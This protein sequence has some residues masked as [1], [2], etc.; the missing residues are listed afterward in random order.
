MRI[1]LLVS[2]LSLLAL[3]L[4]ASAAAARVAGEGSPD[5]SF[6]GDGRVLTDLAEG[7]KDRASSALSYGER[8]IVAGYSIK[9]PFGVRLAVAAYRPDGTLDPTFGTAGVVLSNVED[10]M[11]AE[12]MAIDSFGQIV[13]AGPS[14]AGEPFGSPSVARLLSDGRLDPSFGGGDGMV[15][16]PAELRVSAVRSD[17]GGGILVAGTRGGDAGYNASTE[18]AVF[19]LTRDGSPDPAFGT[20][21]LVTLDLSPGG[22]EEANDMMLDAFGRIVLL[23]GAWFPKSGGRTG[24][25]GQFAVARLLP[26]GK[27]DTAFAGRGYRLLPL[28]EWGSYAT[29]GA[30]DAAGRAILAGKSGN[31]LAFIAM[32]ESGQVD[33]SYG[34]GG[35]ALH[36][37][38]EEFLPGDVAGDSHERLVVALE[39]RGSPSTPRRGVIRCWRLRADGFFDPRFSRDGRV[40][41]RL[42]RRL[43]TARAVAFGPG[44]KILLA[45]WAKLPGDDDTDFAVISLRAAR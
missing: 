40:A 38:R 8:T 7:S 11:A 19:R 12:A 43:G 22:P 15:N 42:G 9:N 33:R 6:S 31:R 4:P 16:V 44:G 21:G 14:N 2:L 45:G 36:S 30:L 10:G 34:S 18:M 13:V 23:G 37:A 29:A 17:S 3:A 32:R 39:S 35:V 5:A 26:D 28:R 1:R 25:T 27:P 41:V 20:G 24:T